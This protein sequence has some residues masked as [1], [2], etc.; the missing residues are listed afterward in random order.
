ML[1]WLSALKGLISGKINAAVHLTASPKTNVSTSKDSNNKSTSQNV[2]F[3]NNG[4]VNIFNFQTQSDGTISR[5]TLE[6]VKEALLPAFEQGDIILLQQDSKK[7]LKDYKEFEAHPD[8][9]S[10]LEF[11]KGKISEL[12]YRLLETGLYESFL[13]END[14]IQKAQQ[15]KGDIIERYGV[16]GKNILNLASAGYFATHIKP[17]Y[18]ALSTQDSFDPASFNKEYEQ[19]VDELPF[20]IF[21]HS[22]LHEEEILD[23]LTKKAEKNI[24]YGVKEE[25]IILNGFGTNADRIEKLIPELKKRYKK[26]APST[27]YL[28]ALKSV[29]ISVYYREATTTG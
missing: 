23:E 9:K 18:E 20:A 28:G 11:F 17:L 24:R 10:L 16:R 27:R 13:L 21:V 3:N 26:I 4:N 22:G 15:I 14:Q 7:L 8:T 2:T 12:D 1:E 19:I 5:E 6:Q 29:Q 25:T